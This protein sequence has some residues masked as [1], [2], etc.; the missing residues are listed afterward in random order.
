MI[1]KRYL[2]RELSH[3]FFAVILVVLLIAVSNKLVRLVA[4]A[5]SGNISPNVLFEVI[6]FQIPDL[7]AFLLPV[8]LFLAI[9][10]CYSRFF[11]DNEIPVML[12]CG[13][14]WQRLL[15]VSLSLG[16]IVML[17]AAMLTCYFAP[18]S[19]QYRE[20]LL[21]TQG[22]ML[23]VQTLAPGRFHSFQKDKLVFYVSDLSEDRSELT[24]V[25]IAEHPN[26]FDEQKEWSLI[27]AQAGKI[28]TDA[29]GATYFSL[30]NGKRYQG[31]PGQ[32]DYSIVQF[33]EYQRL[34]ESPK[35][36]EG[37]FFHRTMP[38]QMLLDNP[39][40]SNLAE[41]QWRLSIPLAAPL[42][43]LLALPLSR[44]APRQGR[45]AR[46]FVA[47]IICIIYFNLLTVSKRMIASGALTPYIGVWWVHG[48]MFMASLL[49]LAKTSGR[50]VQGYQ[51]MRHKFS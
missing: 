11:A 32:M 38:T 9:L 5:A 23:M 25:F 28:Y 20:E 49:F 8:G 24:R 42:L 15:N 48:V 1:I 43:A 18:K 4:Q 27:S 29:N 39:T 41:L 36:Q 46:L 22:P 2:F 47:I 19:A 26:N 3:T 6:L 45:F 10:L 33:E 30:L 12:A 31:T 17:L 37:L 35:M 34:L 13:I 16:F 44:V 50:A 40:P 7:L 14:S 51:W 21:H